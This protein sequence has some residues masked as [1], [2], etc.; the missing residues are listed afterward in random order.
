MRKL[1]II[2]ISILILILPPA[3]I[4]QESSA[5]QAISG[6]VG[7]ARPVIMPPYP[8]PE[9]NLPFGQSHFY[10]VNLRGNG[11]AYVFL[12]AVFSNKEEASL[13]AM[14][15]SF[16]DVLQN[17]NV[18]QVYREPQCISYEPMTKFQINDSML[19]PD[20]ILPSSKC[21]QYQE[22]DYQY[23]WGNTNYYKAEFS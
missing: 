4:A 9:I 20:Y 19:R 10:T 14:K 12:K 2:L 1:L 16:S 21:Q 13:S 18:Y 22:P 23:G 15:L 17:V 5:G 3:A 11:D 7:V 6:S 8:K